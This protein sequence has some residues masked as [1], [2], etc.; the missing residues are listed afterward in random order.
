VTKLE[1]LW[2]DSGKSARDLTKNQRSQELLSSNLV[3]SLKGSTRVLVRP[4]G[5]D[6]VEVGGST[7][8]TIGAFGPP[9][10]RAGARRVQSPEAMAIEDHPAGPTKYDRLGLVPG[11][12]ISGRPII[13]L[14]RFQTPPISG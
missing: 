2:G 3:V 11:F 8:A 7:N 14:A 5:L 13:H 1:K 10:Q 4:I 6:M 12:R 9:Q